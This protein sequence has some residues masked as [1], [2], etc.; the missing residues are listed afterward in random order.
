MYITTR[1]SGNHPVVALSAQCPPTCDTLD[2]PSTE[3]LHISTTSSLPILP[4]PTNNCHHH[5]AS[6]TWICSI[7]ELVSLSDRDQDSPSLWNA[8]FEHR[9]CAVLDV[10][11]DNPA[12]ST[13]YPSVTFAHP[14]PPSD[15]ILRP[16]SH[17]RLTNILGLRQRPLSL[18]SFS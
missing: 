15:S 1:D 13:P 16:S 5:Q 8:I 2:L 4:R 3:A 9:D 6:R 14:Y 7:M 18:L 11:W 12:S 17:R 10:K